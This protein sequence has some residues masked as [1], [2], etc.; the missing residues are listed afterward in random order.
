MFYNFV[1]LY[2]HTHRDSATLFLYGIAKIFVCAA[3][4]A[5]RPWGPPYKSYKLTVF[6]YVK[7]GGERDA[8]PSLY[9]HPNLE[10]YTASS[11]VEVVFV[12]CSNNL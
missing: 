10:C 6:P 7:Q 5:G 11:V 12:T 1:G 2:S 3:K 9:L 4:Y 8:D